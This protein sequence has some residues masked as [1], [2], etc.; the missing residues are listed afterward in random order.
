MGAHLLRL[1]PLVLLTLV[2][3]GPAAGRQLCL[4][5]HPS[6][7]AGRGDCSSCHRGNPAAD[8][9]NIAHARLIAGRYAGFTLGANKSVRVGQG[10]LK[11]Y[12]CQRCHVIGGQGNRLATSL[13]FAASQKAPP[14][15][16]KAI[17]QPAAAMPDFRL[18]EQGETAVITA[19]LAAGRAQQTEN[20][21]QPQVVHFSSTAAGGNDLFSRKCGACHKLLSQRYGALGQGNIGPNLSGLLSPFYPHN[22][23]KARPWTATRLAGWLENPRSVRPWSLMQPVHLTG[24]EAAELVSLM[25]IERGS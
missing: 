4:N 11:Q 22:Y 6:H 14:E 2:V 5:C 13:D 17:C 9:T 20:A 3:T 19:L 7:Y 24:G 18:D 8:R 16:A 1:L 21:D 12:A 15:L 25:L 23:R 10:L